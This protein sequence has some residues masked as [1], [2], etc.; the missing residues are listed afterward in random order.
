MPDVFVP[1][2]TTRYTSLHRILAASGIMNRFSIQYVDNHR[3]ELNTVYPNID[4]F[5]EKFSVDDS[6]LNQM[7]HLA[8]TEKTTI[9]DQDR[10]S[11]KTLL[12]KQLKA[13]IARDLG[14]SADYYKVMWPENESLKEALRILQD[15]KAYDELLKRK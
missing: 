11:D 1:M 5:I 7:I 12:M 10:K 9:S 3:K 6:M 8:E 2:D 15:R 13:Y 14:K 4:N